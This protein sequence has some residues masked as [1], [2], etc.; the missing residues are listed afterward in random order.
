MYVRPLPDN[1]AEQ[2]LQKLEISS[3]YT[4]RV[5]DAHDMLE[6]YNAPVLAYDHKLSIVQFGEQFVGVDFDASRSC[7]Y[8][9]RNAYGTQN[10]FYEATLDALAVR[11]KLLPPFEQ[12][13][14]EKHAGA[15]Q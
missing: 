11:L 14:H 3:A 4:D 6:A 15:K 7:W 1:I 5:I 12:H 13:L 10:S 8:N 9:T 2:I